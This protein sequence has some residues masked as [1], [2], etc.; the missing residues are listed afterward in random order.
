MADEKGGIAGIEIGKGGVGICRPKGGIYVHA[1]AV[2]SGKKLLAHEQTKPGGR[3]NSLH[4]EARMRAQFEPEVGRLTAPLAMYAMADHEG[5]PASV[6]RHQENGY[7][8]SAAVA[9]PTRGLLHVTRGHP[10]Q[11]WARTYRL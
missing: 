5:F 6:C 2:R 9:E 11:N 7:T 1:N 8:T 4:R 10:C 3:E